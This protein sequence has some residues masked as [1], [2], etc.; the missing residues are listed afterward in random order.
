MKK[1]KKKKQQEKEKVNGIIKKIK[2]GCKKMACDRY[3]GLSEEKNDMK[4]EYARNRYQNI[5]GEE[6]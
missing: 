6:K 2:K 1:K 5:S 4:R 3:K